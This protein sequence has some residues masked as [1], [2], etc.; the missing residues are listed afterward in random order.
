[1]TAHAMK[2]DKKKYIDTG[3]DDYLAKPIKP[4]MLSDM[5]EKWIGAGKYDTGKLQLRGRSSAPG[6]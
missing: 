2:G 1:M 4:Q 5:L 6:L 3:M